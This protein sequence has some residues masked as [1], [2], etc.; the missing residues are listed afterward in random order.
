MTKYIHGHGPAATRAHA[1]RTVANSAGHLAGL[2]RPGMRVLDV[3]SASGALTRDL[4]ARVAPGEVVGV[5]SAADAVSLAQ[6]DPS[7]PANLR[8]E[9]GD[10]YALPYP[11]GS[12]DLVHVHQVLHHLTD[13]VAAIRALAPLA[14]P[15]GWLSLREGDYGA[16]FWHPEAVAW[17]SWQECYQLVGRAGGSEVDAGRRLVAW[18]AGA[19]LGGR[20]LV[21]GSLWTYPGFASAAE[22]A[23]SWAERLTESRFVDLAAGLGV[24][25]RESLAATA[26]GLVEWARQ[27]GALFVMPH[28]EA[29]IRL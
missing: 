24:A 19:G 21:S 22:V 5:D 8:F 10:L 7:R 9:V 3:G 14:R 17:R 12:F 18:L 1:G 20:A 13:P 27:P 11:A 4:A 26:A 29:L 28:I 6:A 16:A 2:L 23:A 15:G 25:D